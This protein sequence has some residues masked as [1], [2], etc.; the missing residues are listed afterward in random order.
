MIAGP[1]AERR[2][3]AGRRAPQAMPGRCAVAPVVAL[4]AMSAATA[5]PAPAT[6]APRHPL[7]SCESL[8]SVPLGANASVLSA[9]TNN[10]AD[11]PRHGFRRLEE[12]R[13]DGKTY[14]LVKVLVQPVSPL[15]F[16]ASGGW[17]RGGGGGRDPPEKSKGGGG[18]GG[19]PGRKGGGG[20]GM[21]RAS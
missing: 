4:L 7:V 6:A 3:N 12:S 19:A 1:A 11:A 20:G 18:G 5:A 9:T 2:L 10:T 8:A 14:C 17:R 13:G 16:R 21:Q 15:G